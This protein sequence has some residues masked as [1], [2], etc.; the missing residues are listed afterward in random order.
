MSRWT[1]RVIALAIIFFLGPVAM[2]D[3]WS[4]PKTITEVI[5][6]REMGVL[7]VRVNLSFVHRNPSQCQLA[8]GGEYI[9]IPL[10]GG[11]LRDVVGLSP[12]EIGLMTDAIY[13][14]AIGSRSIDFL[15]SDQGCSSAMSSF[16]VPIAVGVRLLP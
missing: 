15:V 9:D 1:Q 11:T 8:P 13:L 16:E 6:I 2:A 14:A 5:A 12:E 3:V 4:T 10:R 7:R